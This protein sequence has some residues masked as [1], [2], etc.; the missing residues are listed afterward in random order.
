VIP[1]TLTGLSTPAGAGTDAGLIAWG[2]VPSVVSTAGGVKMDEL[3]TGWVVVVLAAGA[4]VVEGGTGFC[5]A[6]VGATV[7]GPSVAG[8][9]GSVVGS[10][11]I[12]TGMSPDVTVVA[13]AWVAGGAGTVVG[14]TVV[15]GASVLVVTGTVVTG[16]VVAGTVVAGTVVAGTV[17][18]TGAGVVGVVIAG[19]VG[20]VAGGT[21]GSV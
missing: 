15:A 18:S 16:T 3:V 1:S 14:A 11:G 10:G 9:V 20:S 5:P 12:E 7:V 6:G 21:D 19:V 8:T 13:G 2:R 17:V 4:P